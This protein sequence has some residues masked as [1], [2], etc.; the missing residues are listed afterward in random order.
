MKDERSEVNHI[1]S[2]ACALFAEDSKGKALSE[3][4][5]SPL[6]PCRVGVT[7]SKLLKICIIILFHITL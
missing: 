7:N 4:N 6:E 5:H 3:E 1:V 2:N